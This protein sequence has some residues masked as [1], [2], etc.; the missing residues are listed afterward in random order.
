MRKLRPIKPSF[1][2][3]IH[4]TKSKK[5]QKQVIDLNELKKQVKTEL[6]ATLRAEV[7]TIVK[8]EIAKLKQELVLNSTQDQLQKSIATNNELKT[9]LLLQSLKAELS[10]LTSI[11]KTDNNTQSKESVEPEQQEIKPETTEKETVSE[12]VESESTQSDEE[13]ENEMI[14]PEKTFEIEGNKVLSHCCDYVYKIEASK[15]PAKKKAEK[16]IDFLEFDALKNSNI[17][18]LDIYSVID[19]VISDE[20]KT[21]LVEKQILTEDEIQRHNSIYNVEETI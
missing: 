14:L 20:L 16:I 2:R 4:I 5:P 17:K 21:L 12:S 15:L 13:L 8:Q 11:A 18:P 3:K 7:S 1:A 19:M 10:N 9:E 6:L